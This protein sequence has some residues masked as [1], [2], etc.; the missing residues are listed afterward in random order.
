MLEKCVYPRIPKILSQE[1]V[2]KLIDSATTPF[3]RAILM[4]LYATGL[5]RAELA[6]LKV[7]DVDSERMVIHVRG[8]RAVKIAM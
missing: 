7:S 8:G 1:E 5:R 6:G 4:T 3:Y 2:A